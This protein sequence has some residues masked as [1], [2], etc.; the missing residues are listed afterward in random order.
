[1]RSV[2]VCCG[3][4]RCKVVSCT[5]VC[6]GVLPSAVVCDL[7]WCAVM[8]GGGSVLWSH[9]VPCGVLCCHVVWSGVTW[10]GLV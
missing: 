8:C 4:P 5:L 7:V 9:D 10:C 2:L 1:M 3:L 6:G